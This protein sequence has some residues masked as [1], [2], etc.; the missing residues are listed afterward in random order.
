LEPINIS[1]LNQFSYCP[2]RCA[3]IYLE[4]EFADNRH[5]ASGN[6]EHA[7]VDRIAQSSNREGARV[8]YALP[9]WSER[10]GLIGKGDVVE[11]WPNGTIYP[12]EYKHGAK[13]QRTNDDLQLAAQTLCL[14]EMFG[15]TISSGAIFHAQSNRRRV[16]QISPELRSLV[17][18]TLASIRKMLSGPALPP[19]LVN[20]PK[21]KECSLREICQPDAQNKLK[22]IDVKQLYC[23][24]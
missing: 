7:R 2:R 8:E 9:I 15:R 16:V 14:E 12:V 20:S 13:K 22:T 19:P 5:T 23:P 10:L 11:F 4:S 21:C 3:L 18:A 6:A 1:A 24:D 17:S